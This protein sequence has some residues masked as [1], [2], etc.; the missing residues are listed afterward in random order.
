MDER[1]D[2][3]VAYAMAVVAQRCPEVEGGP[4]RQSLNWCCR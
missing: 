3:E 2:D 4:D 1:L